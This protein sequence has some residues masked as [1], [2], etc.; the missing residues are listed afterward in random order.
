MFWTA[1]ALEART[2]HAVTALLILAGMYF[3]VALSEEAKFA[4]SP[5]AADYDM[6]R[7]QAG[8]FWPKLVNIR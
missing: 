2:V 1:C 3:F 5:L 4:R 8:L 6:Y 7:R